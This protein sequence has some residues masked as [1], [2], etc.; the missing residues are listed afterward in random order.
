[1]WRWWSPCRSACAS[2]SGRSSPEAFSVSSSSARE[3]PAFG[4]AVPW[5]TDAG[6]LP[7]SASGR[8][9]SS[10]SWLFTLLGGL[11]LGQ[12]LGNWPC[13]ARG[14]NP[15]AGPLE[16]IAGWGEQ[17]FQGERPAC[18]VLVGASDRRRLAQASS[19][20]SDTSNLSR[21]A[22]TS[23]RSRRRRPRSA[24]AASRL[25]PLRSSCRP[26]QLV[27]TAR[28]TATLDRDGHVVAIF[29][30]PCHGPTGF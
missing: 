28:S 21:S 26:P 13:D 15:P 18:A 11:L 30:S 25:R 8:S 17:D 27:E 22:R 23:A 2:P 6:R 24:R 19:R 14:E 10:Q 29:A 20:S 5:D 7:G 12:A 9:C 4:A 16:L 1:M 3:R